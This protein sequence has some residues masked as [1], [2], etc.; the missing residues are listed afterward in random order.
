MK[1]FAFDAGELDR[2]IRIEIASETQAQGS[3]EVT[4]TWAPL[5]NPWAK[6]LPSSSAKDG[7]TIQ[8]DQPAALQRRDFQIRWRPD[9]SPTENFQV[10][11]LGQAF[12]ITGVEELGRRVG[13]QLTGYARAEV[14]A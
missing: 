12:D 1:S 8:A 5:A 13:L 3:G 11:Y 14:A 7:E 4:R 2:R 9:V 10:L 6:V